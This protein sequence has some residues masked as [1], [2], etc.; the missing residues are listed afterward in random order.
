MTI[1]NFVSNL[2]RTT[3][4]IDRGVVTIEVKGQ[5]TMLPAIL[6]CN[7]IHGQTWAWVFHPKSKKVENVHPAFFTGGGR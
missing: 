6:T 1:D 7:S 2:H 3:K 4:I 5:P